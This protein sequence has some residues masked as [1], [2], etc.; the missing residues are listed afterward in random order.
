MNLGIVGLGEQLCRRHLPALADLQIV[1]VAVYDPDPAALDRF[2]LIFQELFPE[3]RIPM[4]AE[5][6]QSIAREV[7]I[8]DVVIPPDAHIEVFSTLIQEGCTFL[9]EKPFCRSWPEAVH[10]AKQASSAG[11]AAGCLENWIFDPVV[12]DLDAVIHS[13]DIGILQ[14]ISIQFPNAG[15]SIYPEQSPWRAQAGKG[16][17]LLDWGSHAAG[18]AW[19]LV[20]EDSKFLSAN[21]VDIRASRQ[22]SL[23][24]GAFR[25][26]EVEDIAKFELLFERPEGRTILANIDSSWNSPWMWSPGHSY[27]VLR[28][29]A[30]KGAADISVENSPEGRCYRMAIENLNGHRQEI[31]LGLLKRCDPTASAIENALK[32]LMNEPRPHPESDLNFGV[33]VQLMIGTALL[34]AAQGKPV[35]TG[36][37]EAWCHR[38]LSEAGNPHDAWENALATLRTAANETFSRRV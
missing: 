2:E 13:G 5:D 11:V 34:S 23:V 38:V 18:L 27:R 21:A 19:H 4:A 32:S 22:R 6:L 10:I 24:S 31:E 29:D 30:S 16:G 33:T 3:Q 36:D 8:V 1:P 15:L 35:K 12:I 7:D 28:V 20:G 26:M 37:F 17:A 9:C 14:R 25:D